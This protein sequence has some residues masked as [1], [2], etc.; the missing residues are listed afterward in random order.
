MSYEYGGWAPYVSVAERRRKAERAAARLQKSGHLVSP[1]TI[2]GRLI[3]TTFW[4]KAWCTNIEGYRDYESR[5]PRGRTYVRNGSVIDLQIAPGRITATVSGSRLYKVTVTVKETAQKAWQSICTDCAGNI[6]SMV[7][8][9]QGRFSKAVMERLCHQDR[10]LFPRPSEIQFTCSCPDHAVMCKHVAAVLYGI[11]A[12]LDQQPELLFRL[13]AVNEAD[14]LARIDAATM[15]PAKTPESGR[16]LAADDVSALFGLDMEAPDAPVPAFPPQTKAPR[17]KCLTPAK[18]GATKAVRSVAAQKKPSAARAETTKT[19][20]KRTA[21]KTA[22]KPAS[23]ERTGTHMATTTTTA[24][25]SRR[26]AKAAGG[27]EARS[28]TRVSSPT[29]RASMRIRNQ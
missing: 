18:A 1:V 8:L 4:G 2:T 20:S 11:G 29:K 21:T 22:S 19:I 25:G 17:Q 15:L 23:V 10:G 13:R 3:A 12:R 28:I 24:T 14:L 27:G 6:D 16:I 26:L 9:L 7:E 5:L